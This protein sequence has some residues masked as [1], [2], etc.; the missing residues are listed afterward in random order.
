V[1]TKSF[2]SVTAWRYKPFKI[3]NKKNDHDKIIKRYKKKEKNRKGYVLNSEKKRK[4]M[5]IEEI[6]V[7]RPPER[8]RL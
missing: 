4:S 5:I 2:V 3:K 1:S 8:V 7:I 6:R